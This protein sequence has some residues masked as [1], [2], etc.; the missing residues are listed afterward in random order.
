[1]GAE[2]LDQDQLSLQAF[3]VETFAKFVDAL[4]ARQDIAD[5]NCLDA[6][7]L[8]AHR[9]GEGQE[10]ADQDREPGS[11]AAKPAGAS[12]KCTDAQ[13]D[14]NH[15][16]HDKECPVFGHAHRSIQSEPAHKQR[17]GQ[18]E[19]NESEFGAGLGVHDVRVLLSIW[20]CVKPFL[21]WGSS[22]HVPDGAAFDSFFRTLLA[23][24]FIC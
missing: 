22:N 24:K 19:G 17:G 12:H 23:V 4:E 20:E 21:P 1:M 10:D 18:A 3:R 2:E 7:T 13:Q 6:H 16:P 9:D 11:Q 15:P 14:R 5:L 8:L